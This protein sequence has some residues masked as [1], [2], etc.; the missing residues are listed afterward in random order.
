MRCSKTDSG[1]KADLGL[2]FKKC[3]NESDSKS[4][5]LTEVC[6]DYLIDPSVDHIYSVLVPSI[7]MLIC[8]NEHGSQVV[9]PN[10]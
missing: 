8:F 1:P 10:F 7:E 5:G 2:L 3:F 6:L 9:K 4:D